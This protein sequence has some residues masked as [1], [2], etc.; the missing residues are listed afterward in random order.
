MKVQ[1]RWLTLLAILVGISSVV[2]LVFQ[3]DRSGWAQPTTAREKAGHADR[4][5][6][7]YEEERV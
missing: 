6:R 7:G 2:L 4:N 3:F 5:D 1:R